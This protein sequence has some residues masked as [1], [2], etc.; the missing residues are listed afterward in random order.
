[1]CASTPSLSPRSGRGACGGGLSPSSRG[2]CG[3]ASP[4]TWARLGPPS[5]PASGA[6]SG[7]LR[8][9]CWLRCGSAGWRRTW[10]LATPQS[11]PAA[12]ASTGSTRVPSP[13]SCEARACSPTRRRTAP[14]SGLSAGRSTGTVGCGSGR[15][16]SR[17]PACRPT[18]SSAIRRSRP[19]SVAAGGS[20]LSAL[21]WSRR[22]VGALHQT[23]SPATQCSAPAPK[24]GSG[25]GRWCC[26]PRRGRSTLR[27][28]PSRRTAWSS[29]ARRGSGGRKPWR[30]WPGCGGSRSSPASA[31]TTAPWAPAGGGGTP[32]GSCRRRARLDLRPTSSRTTR[33]SARATRG[34]NGRGCSGCLPR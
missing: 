30:P 21:P 24:A 27:R 26:S 17:M 5:A 3:A 18:S 16:R 9:A 23:W 19:A 10:L 15:R 4:R 13:G 25:R 2:P 14:R 6:G 12:R 8:W 33:C 22:G 32:S 20:R 31:R 11:V 34:A 29:R 28:T 1:M 7:V